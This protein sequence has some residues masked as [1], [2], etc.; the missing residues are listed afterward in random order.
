MNIEVNNCKST[1]DSLLLKRIRLGFFPTPIHELKTLS[2]E[3]NGPRIFIKRE[4]NTGLAFGGSKT[5]KLEYLIYD[6]LEK[7]C[8]CIVMVGIAP[9]SN[10]CRMA[11]AACRKV[12]LECYLILGGH[13]SND[14]IQGNTL[15]NLMLDA[16]LTYCEDVD[17][18]DEARRELEK[19]LKNKG[20]TP[21][22]IPAGG[23]NEV[24]TLGF[25]DA[26]KEI[27]E[28]EKQ[29]KTTFDTIFFASSSFGTQAGLVIANLVYPDVPKQLYGVAIKKK[30]LH[31]ESQK[32]VLM[33]IITSFDKTFKTNIIEDHSKELKEGVIV[34]ETFNDPGYAI[35]S[36]RDLNGVEMF[37]KHEA[38][39]LDPVYTG[40]A[41]GALIELIKKGKFTKENNI[42]FIHSGG[43]PTVFSDLFKHNY[44]N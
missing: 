41:A 32:E 31:M 37:A 23:S 35:M 27:L 6:A 13:P 15:L 16:H 11:A 10:S 19:E 24:C 21:Y 26:F 22:Y 18:I 28:Q 34:D 5:R 43:T 14:K 1:L 8:D 25:I 17:K 12:N 36:E 39:I 42:L 4:D 33:N 40:R 38:I 7:K 20:K 29:M 9:Q 30:K 44:K 3:L 2:K